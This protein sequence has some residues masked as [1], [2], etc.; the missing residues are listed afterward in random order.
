MPP[1][2]VGGYEHVTSPWDPLNADP[3]PHVDPAEIIEPWANGPPLPAPRPEPEP[4]WVGVQG[5]RRGDRSATLRT[6]F[7]AAIISAALT[8]VATFAVFS[9]TWPAASVVASPSEPA[10]ATGS[11]APSLA[12][13]E[14]PSARAADATSAGTDSS[15]TQIVARSIPFVVTITTSSSG[16]GFGS[17]QATGLG[18]GIIF[19]ANGWILTNAH[20]VAGAGAITVQLS[21]GRQLAG[22]VYGVASTT[23]LAVVKVGATGLPAASIGHSNAVV[24]GE[25]IIAI[26]DPLGQYPGSVTTGVVSG[27]ERSI[28]I[29]GSATLTGL[30]QTDAAIN[31]GD[32]GGPLLDPAGRVIGVTTATSGRAQGISFAIPIDVARPIMAEALAGQPIN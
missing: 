18:S 26:G 16:N 13:T 6:A 8:A 30:I 3:R 10:L 5:G 15:V 23:D 12:P 11:S 29:R 1:A 31:L 32:S 22:Q 19:D 2:A 24:A 7:V 4:A 27:L 14:T 9:L 21:D 25:A 17:D 20:V 28:D